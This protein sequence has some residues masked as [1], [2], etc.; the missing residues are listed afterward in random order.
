M[1]DGLRVEPGAGAG[2]ASRD[3]A[4][5]LGLADK[6]AGRAELERLAGRLDDLHDRLW[7]EGTRSVLLVLQGIDAAGKDGAIRKV[8]AG[9]NPQGCSIASFKA[10]SDAELAHDYLWRVHAMC[11]RRGHLGVFNRSH[12]EDVVAAEIVGAVAPEQRRLRYRHL[13]ELERM[14]HDEGTAIVKV[15]LHI[16]K[17]EQR[18]RLQARLDDPTKG[19]KFKAGDL[20][21]R[22]RWDD[23]HALYEAALSA[24]SSEHAPWYVV[25]AD[26]KW[27]RDVAVASLLVA[28][29]ERLEPKYPP[30]D[31]EV[32][33]LRVE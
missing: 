9:L 24:T 20:D 32:R 7:A 30:L 29:L 19:W 4:T 27:V 8:L 15:F 21:T 16:S 10:P 12:Y 23:Y 33:G 18:A 11:P 31:P 6:A 22:A 25:P 28:T 13:V 17:D 1:L 5:R 14:L 3:P 26:H 2:L